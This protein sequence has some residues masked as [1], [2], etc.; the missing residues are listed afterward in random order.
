MK[1]Y[2]MNVQTGGYYMKNNPFTLRYGTMSDSVVTRN[3]SLNRIIS[4]FT[5]QTNM[6]AYLIT[7][8]RGSGKTVLLKTVEEEMIKRP[9]WVV[10]N[11]NP[12]GDIISSIASKMFDL[13]VIKKIVGKITLTINLGVITLTRESGEKTTDPEIIINHMLELYRSHNLNVL[14]SIDEVNDTLEFKKFINF[15]QILI[16]KKYGI[17]LLMTAL[18]ENVNALI[19]DKAT[20]FLSRAPKIVLEPLPLSTIALN[21][22]DTFNIDYSIAAKMA[23]LTNGYAFAYQVLGYLMFESGKKD[24]DEELIKQYDKY[25]WSNGYNK[26]WN[27][28]T[29][30]ERKFL[31]VLAN[32]DGKKES[33][34]ENGF[35]NVNYSQYR[36][37]LIEKG[38]ISMPKMGCLEFVLPRFKEFINFMKEFE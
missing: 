10:I 11:I 37:R 36:R 21:Y 16:A 4:S 5:E 8:I 31:T 22:S 30:V 35:S 6:Y 19:N 33:I 29:D 9:N 1:E 23:K 24:V 13:A 32:S 15:Y 28:L 7:G 20:T 12:Q 18:I 27:D 26:F 2:I 17:Y 14:I 3:D 34:L 38:L 25:L